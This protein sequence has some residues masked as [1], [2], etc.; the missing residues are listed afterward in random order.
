MAIFLFWNTAKH[1]LTIEVARLV[2]IHD[3]DVVVLAEADAIPVVRLLETVNAVPDVNLRFHNV[4]GQERIRVYSRFPS[5]SIT[6]VSD[7]GGISIRRVRVPGC[8]EVLLVAAHL[9]SK[10]HW[11]PREQQD[12]CCRMREFIDDAEARSGHQ[13]TLVVGD[14]NMNPFEH[15]VVSSEG[16]HAVMTRRDAARRKR[17][18]AGV[19]RHFFYN[20]MWA[21]FGERPNGPPGTYYKRRSTPLSYFWNIFDQVLVRPALLDA[22]SEQSLQILTVAG[23][24]PLLHRSGRPDKVGVSDHLPILFELRL[25]P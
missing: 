14:L 15:G 6:K 10:F 20:P 9:P 4:V 7:S 22:F 1:D 17:L 11:N 23:N 2:Q 24:T 16:L 18:V 25:T 19:E 3:V 8:D 21:H 12:F 5:E 13:R